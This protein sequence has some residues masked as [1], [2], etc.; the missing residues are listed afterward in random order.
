MVL[1]HYGG[2]PEALTVALPVA[3]FAGFMLL[4][5]RAR[6]RERE[7]GEGGGAETGDG[8]PPAEPPSAAPPP[9]G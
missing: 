6:Q 4:E 1:A 5:K 9:Q 2:A 3:V 8:S 7:R